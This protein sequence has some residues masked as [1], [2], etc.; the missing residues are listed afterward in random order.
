MNTRLLKMV[1]KHWGENRAYQ[2]KWCASVRFL[3]TN[4]RLAVPMR[5]ETTAH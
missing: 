4:W 2:R 5:R 3:G 1:R